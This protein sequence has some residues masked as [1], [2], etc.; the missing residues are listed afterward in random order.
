MDEI[1]I[2]IRFKEILENKQDLHSIVMEMI[3][4]FSPL[5]RE[6]KLELFPEYTNHGFKHINKVLE[7]TD[8]IIEENTIIKLKEKDIGVMV[9]SVFMHDIAMHLTYEVFMEL[10]KGKFKDRVDRSIDNRTW[11][12]LWEEYL[13]EA[14]RWSGKTK[15][16]IFGTDIVIKEPPLDRGS[17]TE[18]DR[19]LI[20]EF[21]RRNHPRLAYEI[22]CWGIPTLNSKIIKNETIEIP[23]DIDNNM[24]KL[25][26]LIARSH[27]MNLWECLKYIECDFG[28]SQVR[29]PKNIHAIYIMILLRISDYLDIENSR[30]NIPILRYKRINSSISE[31]EWLKH[32]SIEYLDMEYQDDPESIYIHV[33]Q[34]RE[35]KVYLAIIDLIND[36]QEELDTSWAVLGKVYGNVGEMKLKFRRIHSNINDTEF[37]NKNIDFIPE[38]I[39]FD[40]NPD[41]LKLLIKPLYGDNVAYGV[42]ELLQNSIDACLERKEIEN[43]DYEG[44]INLSVLEEDNNYYFEIRDNGI[45]MNKDILVNYFLVAGA[46][47]RNSNDWKSIYE[48]D[49]N[50]SLIPRSGRFGVGVFASFI[51]G[52][53]IEVITTR[54]GEDQQYSFNGNIDVDQIEINVKRCEKSDAGTRI[55]I[56][57]NNKTFFDLQNQY[58]KNEYIIGKETRWI[59]W[60]Y[61][62]E[63]KIHIEVPKEWGECG[64]NKNDINLKIKSIPNQTE[65]HSI[66][67]DGYY[68]VD[69]NYKF[70]D[71]MLFCN[72]IIISSGY[73]SYEFFNYSFPYRFNHP[74]VSVIDYDGN[75]PLT[76]DRNHL[77]NKKLPFEDELIRSIA[78]DFI[79]ELYNCNDVSRLTDD[80]I[81]INKV[82]Y[83]H[84]SIGTD[85]RYQCL[86]MYDF[87]LTRKGYCILSDYY[88]QKL[89][90]NKINKIWVSNNV[91]EVCDINL[92]GKMNNIIISKESINTNEK[93]RE[94]IDRN[95][96]IDL[97]QDYW[98]DGQRVFIRK[99][100]FHRMFEDGTNRIRQGFKYGMNIEIES[101]NWCCIAFGNI[102]NS[103]ISIDDI[104]RNSNEIEMFV[105]YHLKI[106]DSQPKVMKSYYDVEFFANLLGKRDISSYIKYKNEDNVSCKE[107]EV[108]NNILNK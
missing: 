16:S 11:E 23:N 81:I 73:D 93:L 99:N 102:G 47:F 59:S 58:K 57:L 31:L 88:I 70:P 46:S 67:P 98:I 5:I 9:M 22:C 2:P 6:N 108:Q 83:N 41:I 74:N 36:M 13:S 84:S 51:L 42:R 18:N 3:R 82:Q 14:K 68:R 21:L 12:K 91:E 61:A 62:D 56:K 97:G 33:D 54:L 50:E 75:L 92:I 7:I 32:N 90:I 8:K 87:L 29:N 76:L 85:V 48:N 40:A 89:N 24:K 38:R 4:K 35:S 79:E 15:K 30:V 107:I 65:W 69:W 66:K 37:I 95:T 44:S 104:E 39:K 17:A 55:K 20:G 86:N 71:E 94:I 34:I 27:G 105:E 26:G 64:L 60:Y 1:V 77:S 52:E 45:G 106:S 100:Y 101:E 49:K 80:S 28:R 43:N 72:G 63:P 78:T 19:K 25:I 96:P 53:E 10:V 103:N